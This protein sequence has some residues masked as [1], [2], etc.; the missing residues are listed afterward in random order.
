MEQIYEVVLS[1][2]VLHIVFSE[3]PFLY[4][5]SGHCKEFLINFKLIVGFLQICF[6][7]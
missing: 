5:L 2:A 7:C 4:P 1:V 3:T 6:Q